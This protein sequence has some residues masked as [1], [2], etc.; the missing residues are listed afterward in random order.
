MEPSSK[1]SS[2]PE[3]AS[4]TWIVFLGF[5][6][7]VI[8]TSC[9]QVTASWKD[10]SCIA[11]AELRRGCSWRGYCVTPSVQWWFDGWVCCNHPEMK[12]ERYICLRTLLTSCILKQSESW[13]I[14]ISF[15]SCLGHIIIE[16]R[17]AAAKPEDTRSL[18]VVP[19]DA[20]SRDGNR[21]VN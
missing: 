9:N 18:S 19:D 8:W 10:Y 7:I 13:P 15:S 1:G 16:P 12:W 4:Q 14:S 21:P 20:D 17:P 2:E 6:S 11:W 5:V 3:E